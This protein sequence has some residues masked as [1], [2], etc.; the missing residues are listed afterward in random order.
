MVGSMDEERGI[1]I[2]VGMGGTG[3]Y[4]DWEGLIF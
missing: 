2:L 3:F 1:G 4:E